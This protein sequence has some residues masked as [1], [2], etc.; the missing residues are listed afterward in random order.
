MVAKSD[1]HL[2]PECYPLVPPREILDRQAALTEAL[3]G[4]VDA[5][6]ISWPADLFYLTGSN[7]IG[8]LL[9]APGRE[10]VFLVRRTPDRAAAE[11]PLA[12]APLNGFGDLGRAVED[13]LGRRPARL[14]LALD[15]T[16][17]RE[18][19]SLSEQLGGP[20]LFDLSPTIMRLR[21]VKSQ[22]E[23]DQITQ[24]GRIN[25][26]VMAKVPR[27]F[28]PHMTEA[29]LAGAMMH[30]A[31]AL[32]CQAFMRTRS[33]VGEMYPWH[34]VAGDRALLT[35]RVEAPFGGLG[36]SPSFPQ[37]ASLAPIGPGEMILADFGC[38]YLGYLADVT[39]MFSW[40]P[41]PERGLEAYRALIEIQERLMAA[42]VPGADGQD[43]YRLAMET[44]EELG[45][46]LE[47]L[48]Q[49]AAEI[50]FVGHGVGLEIS[51]PPYLAKNRKELLEAGQTLAL[52]LK[53]VLPG[54]GAVGLENT[55]LVTPEGGRLLSDANEE[56][57]QIEAS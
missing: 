17:H 53:M 54:L 56:F 21:S 14:G 39:R 55:V 8:H 36:A 34:V 49:G 5:A 41:P 40:G 3:A 45:F 25:R 23:I 22:W 26:E 20:E 33:V 32:G 57:I 11:G 1:S 31:M 7:Q 15:V 16:P 19:A 43:L 10:P 6:L 2:F 42:L 37:G 50:K 35:S 48:G 27:M 24:A 28:K 4:E 29:D 38:C 46:G 51:E 44:A 9:V 13:L 47:F 12:V 52:E 30:E 18:V